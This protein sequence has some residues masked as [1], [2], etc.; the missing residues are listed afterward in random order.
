MW[1]SF[2]LI[3]FLVAQMPNINC[4]H[5]IMKILNDWK[6]KYY[7]I[8]NISYCFTPVVKNS[9][10]DII[11]NGKRQCT[12]NPWRLLFYEVAPYST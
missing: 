4:Y 3:V 6:S 1:P 2:L 8:L 10:L 9:N 11:H 12:L 7:H 5:L